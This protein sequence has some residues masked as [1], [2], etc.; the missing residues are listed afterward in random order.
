[1]LLGA[2][3]HFFDRKNLTFDTLKMQWVLYWHNKVEEYSSTLHF[4]D[5]PQNIYADKLSQLH[6][7]VTL[8]LIV[9]GKSPIEPAVITYD[10]NQVYFLEQVFTGLSN[11][12]ICKRLP[13]PTKN[14]V[15]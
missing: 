4:I 12:D 11:D 2:V 7:F 9:E 14:S 3:I 8:A 6:C 1:M 10:G 5:G 13:Q 15:S